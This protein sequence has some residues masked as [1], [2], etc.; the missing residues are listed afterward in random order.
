MVLK[1]P[2]TVWWW[3]CTQLSS[4]PLLMMKYTQSSQWHW[5]WTSLANQFGVNLF[6]KV[7]SFCWVWETSARCKDIE[8]ACPLSSFKIRRGGRKREAAELKTIDREL[9]SLKAV[10]SCCAWSTYATH[11][12]SARVTYLSKNFRQI[13]LL[14]PQVLLVWN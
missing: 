7:G 11:Q 1:V 5:S 2:K 3:L 8:L 10:T 13:P 14:P 4:L 6:A 12:T 9:A